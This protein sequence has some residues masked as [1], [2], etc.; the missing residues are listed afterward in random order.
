MVVATGAVSTAIAM[1]EQM[2]PVFQALTTL[3]GIPS[4]SL[5]AA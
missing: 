2:V 1:A 3:V 4:N 5:T